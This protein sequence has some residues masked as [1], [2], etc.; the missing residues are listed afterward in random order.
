MPAESSKPSYRLHMKPLA[1]RPRLVARSTY[2][3]V[4]VIHL[5]RSP[6]AKLAWI[7]GLRT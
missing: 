5:H 3:T 6:L 4:S 1:P 2:P 7:F